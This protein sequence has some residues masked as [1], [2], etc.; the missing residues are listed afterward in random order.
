MWRSSFCVKKFILQ[1]CRLIASNFTIKQTPSQVFFDSILSPSPMLPLCF[2]LSPPP[3]N[4][5]EP[6]LPPPPSACPQH[7][8]ETLLFVINFGYPLPLPQWCY[9]C[10]VPNSVFDSPK[11]FL[12]EKYDLQFFQNGF[13]PLSGFNLSKRS[14]LDWFF[15]FPM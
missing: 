8:W 15:S 5:E 12:F 7:L 13:E 4:F 9:F 6:P 14:F 2:N 10:M 3:S 1:T 11:E